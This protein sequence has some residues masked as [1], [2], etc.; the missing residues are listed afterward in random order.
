MTPTVTVPDDVPLVEP[1]VP[2]PVPPP[3]A[4]AAP[5][6]AV[7]TAC[8]AVCRTVVARPFESVVTSVEERLP[9]VVENE[10][11]TDV[12][13]LPFVSSTFAVIVESP[14]TAGTVAGDAPTPT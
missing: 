5:T 12:S 7:T 10:T 3:P 9:A 4:A 1:P 6:D 2:V 13:G 11:V 8:V 14:P